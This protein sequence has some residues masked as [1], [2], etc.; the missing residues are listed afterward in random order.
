MITPPGG[1]PASWS[2]GGAVTFY[3]GVSIYIA[4]SPS[5]ACDNELTSVLVLL[6]S[7]PKKGRGRQPEDRAQQPIP[8]RHGGHGSGMSF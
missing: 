4:P 2:A 5:S 8:L 7:A 6:V 3:L 1:G